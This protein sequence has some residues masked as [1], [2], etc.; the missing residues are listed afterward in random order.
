[1]VSDESEFKEKAKNH[2]YKLKDDDT[3]NNHSTAGFT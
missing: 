1:M 3:N 2:A